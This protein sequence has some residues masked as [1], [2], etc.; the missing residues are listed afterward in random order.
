MEWRKS[1]ILTSHQR[2]YSP[3]SVIV[4]VSNPADTM[5][6]AFQKVSGIDPKIIVK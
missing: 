2:K 5:A 1:L 3:E 6:Y 4:I